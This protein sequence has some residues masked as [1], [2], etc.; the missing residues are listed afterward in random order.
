MISISEQRD[1]AVGVI[2]ALSFLV[3][4]IGVGANIEGLAASGGLAFVGPRWAQSGRPSE[5]SSPQYPSSD[6]LSCSV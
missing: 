2:A 5:R 4:L 1:T 3:S 6:A